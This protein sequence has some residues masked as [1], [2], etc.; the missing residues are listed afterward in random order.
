MPLG[1]EIRRFK[2][3][4]AAVT[5]VYNYQLYLHLFRDYRLD[6]NAGTIPDL[7][8]AF[9][10]RKSRKVR[11]KL[12]KDPVILNRADNSGYCFPYRKALCILL[13]R[14]QK[15][16]MSKTDMTIFSALD[17]SVNIRAYRKSVSG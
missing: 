5:A 15:L 11:R 9:Q 16:L 8:T 12:D 2:R 3:H 13:P 7:Y 4:T 1:Y 6:I 10:L 17:Y 14:S